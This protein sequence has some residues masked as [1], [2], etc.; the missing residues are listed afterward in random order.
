MTGL[1]HSTSDSGQIIDRA[2]GE[3]EGSLHHT[4][5]YARAIHRGW[6]EELLGSLERWLVP[7]AG[8]HCPRKICQPSLR[9]VQVSL[10]EQAQRFGASLIGGAAPSSGFVR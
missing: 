6:A 8:L 4:P 5:I 10:A 3:Q 2:F 7:P 1:S 9:H